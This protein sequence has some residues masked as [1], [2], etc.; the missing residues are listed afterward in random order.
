MAQPTN[1]KPE[2]DNGPK[3]RYETVL[4]AIRKE[5][6]KIRESNDKLQKLQHQVMLEHPAPGQILMEVTTTIGVGLEHLRSVFREF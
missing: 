5:A 4:N 6:Q 3:L 2:S 1:T